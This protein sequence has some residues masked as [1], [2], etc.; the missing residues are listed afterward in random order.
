MAFPRRTYSPPVRESHSSGGCPPGNRFVFL[1][2]APFGEG[3]TAIP[4]GN[5]RT[6]QEGNVL[7]VHEMTPS[8]FLSTDGH[9]AATASKARALRFREPS[10]TSPK[11]PRIAFKAY[12][13]CS[14]SNWVRYP[15]LR[16]ICSGGHH[17]W[18]ACCRENHLQRGGSLQT[19]DPRKGP[20]RTQRR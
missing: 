6:P 18:M 7:P 10:R 15:D 20:T 8:H 4:R 19:D 5:P 2:P 1:T 11:S 13:S 16:K 14:I 12:R 9:Q 3:R 17:P